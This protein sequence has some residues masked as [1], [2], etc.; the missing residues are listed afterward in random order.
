MELNKNKRNEMINDLKESLKNQKEMKKLK[1]IEE[2]DIKRAFDE[3]IINDYNSY[4]MELSEKEQL[5]KNKI[6]K[7]KEELEKQ[8]FENNRI[9]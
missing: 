4:K 5:K 3:K 9:K 1:E 7:Y 8:I 6:Q 2:N